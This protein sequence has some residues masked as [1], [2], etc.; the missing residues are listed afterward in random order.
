VH[1]RAAR[2]VVVERFSR[3]GA[4]RLA[5]AAAGLDALIK[6]PPA[7]LHRRRRLCRLLGGTHSGVHA[8]VL[9]IRLRRGGGA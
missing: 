9:A 7:A 2:G 6:Q 3:S 8:V 1:A 4:R 5:H